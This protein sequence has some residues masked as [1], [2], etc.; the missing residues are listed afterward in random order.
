MTYQEFRRRQILAAQ[1][2]RARQRFTRLRY[3]RARFSGFGAD[4]FAAA[5]ESLGL[6][7]ATRYPLRSFDATRTAPNASLL[8]VAP[9]AGSPRFD[10]SL[11]PSAAIGRSAFQ[12][13][14]EALLANQ[15]P[16]F[17]EILLQYFRAANPPPADIP[18]GTRV[19]QWYSPLDHGRPM[20]PGP[21]YA[22]PGP[23]EWVHV[24]PGFIGIGFEGA[25]QPFAIYAPNQ[26]PWGFR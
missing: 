2:A 26:W 10:P 11:T 8:S 25:S 23:P 9:G 6:G 3:P 12:K 21:V 13:I 5:P 22:W 4:E 19:Q 15:D 18:A 24:T 1:R 16:G 20:R 17:I 7:L 14:Q